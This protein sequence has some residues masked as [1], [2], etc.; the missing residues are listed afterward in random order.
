[1]G[2]Q[3]MHVGNQ[4]RI[5]SL[6]EGARSRLNTVYMIVFFLGGAAG[7]ALSSAAWARWQWSGVCIMALAFLAA[8]ALL[9]MRGARREAAT[10]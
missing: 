8:A 4:T 2:Q 9:L 10:S 3:S 1:M 5:F 7:S 6:V